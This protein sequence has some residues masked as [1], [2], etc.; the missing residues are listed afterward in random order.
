[1]PS[2]WE[3]SPLEEH[4]AAREAWLSHVQWGLPC[5]RPQ[6]LLGLAVQ[7]VLPSP[8]APVQTDPRGGCAV[9]GVSPALN[10]HSMPGPQKHF[11]LSKAGG[12]TTTLQGLQSERRL[13]THENIFVVREGWSLNTGHFS[14]SHIVDHLSGRMR[15]M[16]TPC[17]PSVV[18]KRSALLLRSEKAFWNKTHHTIQWPM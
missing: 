9:C 17:E 13:K 6:L 3:V 5:R 10:T 14:S 16:K 7:A 1:M 8:S 2:F 18:F 11:L 15:E 4:K 12:S